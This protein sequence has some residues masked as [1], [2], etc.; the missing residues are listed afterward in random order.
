MLHFEIMQLGRFRK[1]QSTKAGGLFVRRTDIIL[2]KTL[3][4][5]CLCLL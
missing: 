5:K 2:K 1:K 3:L 4:E